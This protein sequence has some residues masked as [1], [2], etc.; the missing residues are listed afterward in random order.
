M[1]VTVFLSPHW[2]TLQE[3][4]LTLWSENGTETLIVVPTTSMRSYWLSVLAEKVKGVSGDSV[5]VLDFLA[6]K[7]ASSSANGLFRLA[8]VLER[9]LAAIEARSE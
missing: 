9:K 8:S 7:L 1:K 4:A 3:K 2:S 5:S 6:Y